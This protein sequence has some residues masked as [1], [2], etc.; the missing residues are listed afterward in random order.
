MSDI[1]T[2]A[3]DAMGGDNA[4]GEIVKGAVEAVKRRNDIRI[5][6]TGQETV[7]KETLSEY[8]YPKE[9]IQIVNATEVIETAEP[10]VMAIRRKK[11][12]SIVV[13][14]N[15]VK[16][17]ERMW[18][19]DLLIWYSSQRWGLFTWRMSSARRIRR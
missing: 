2:I 17:G 3:L 11:D 19:Q 7:L 10:P 16:H 8:E 12:S 9:Q 13:A 6:L 18:M 15:L 5:L 14:M 4:P 1:T